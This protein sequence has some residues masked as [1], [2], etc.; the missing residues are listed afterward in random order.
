MTELIAVVD[1]ETHHLVPPGPLSVGR[2]PDNTIVVGGDRSVSRR[3]LE[4]RFST[5]E[6]SVKDVSANGAWVGDRRLRT[7]TIRQALDVRIGTNGTVVHFSC[8]P[9]AAP[10]RHAGRTATTEMTTA[11]DAPWPVTGGT[12]SH[13]LDKDLVTIGRDP[14]NDVV[15]PDL[16]ISRRHAALCRVER[17]W[18]L[19]D[20]GSGNGTYL[21][22]TKVQHCPVSDGAIIGVGQSLLSLRGDTLFEQPRRGVGMTARGISYTLPSGKQLLINVNLDAPG[23]SMVVVA[24]GSGTGKSTL[25]GVLG[26]LRTPS[27]GQVDIGGHS[28]GIAGGEIRHAVG[29]VPQHESLHDELTVE[30]ELCYSGL[31]RLSRDLTPG[32]GS[33]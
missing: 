4:L 30:E 29:F 31:L 28:T 27:A 9:T 15:I 23:A 11:T 22:G 21:N 17:G 12:A 16:T 3:H 2:G 19:H 6:W 8:Y 13:R 1:G 33:K 5:G 25:L 7:E 14:T 26:G 18:Q 32:S 24:G 10:A 20:Y